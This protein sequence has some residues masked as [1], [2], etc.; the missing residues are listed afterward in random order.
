[1]SGEGLRVLVVDDEQPIRRFLRVALA[2]QAYTVFE[3]ASGQ[4]ALV[5]ATAGK[6]TARPRRSVALREHAV[7]L[8]ASRW[9][10]QRS[11]ATSDDR[12]FSVQTMREYLKG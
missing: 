8:G 11:A 12:D 2:S 4:E 9:G 7:R 1:M 3:A 10:V 6:H 5:S